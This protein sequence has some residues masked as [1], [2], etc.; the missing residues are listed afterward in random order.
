MRRYLGACFS[1]DMDI[2]R[3]PVG[4]VSVVVSGAVVGVCS[5]TSSGKVLN[6]MRSAFFCCFVAPTGNRFL[7]PQKVHSITKTSAHGFFAPLLSFWIVCEAVRPGTRTVLQHLQTVRFKSAESLT[8][9]FRDTVCKSAP[10]WSARFEYAWDAVDDDNWS[11]EAVPECKVRYVAAWYR[12]V[13]RA[14][15]CLFRIPLTF[16]GL[17]LA[18]LRKTRQCLKPVHCGFD[19]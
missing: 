5:P 4:V 18:M 11:E 6:R 7:A 1:V 17:F 9:P 10:S 14:C 15:K 2:A 3:Q 13:V 12:N 16:G 8:C 19:V